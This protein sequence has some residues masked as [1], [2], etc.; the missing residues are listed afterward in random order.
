MRKHILIF[1]ICISIFVIINELFSQ[2]IANTDT[3]IET[4]KIN[5]LHICLPTNTKE[6]PIL[7]NREDENAYF[8]ENRGQIRND[9]VRY[10]LQGGGV[11]FLDDGVIFEIYDNQGVN[12]RESEEPLFSNNPICEDIEPRNSV[13]LKLNFKDANGIAPTGRGLLPHKSNYFY[14]NDS[15]KWC[16][17]VPNYQEIYYENLYNNIDLRY[18]SSDIGIKYDFIVHPGGEPNN[19]RMKYEGAEKLFINPQGDIVIRSSSC[20]FMDSQPYIYQTNNNHE[21][22]IN[23]R[24]NIFDSSTYGFEIPNE[25]DSNKPI[26]IDP[27]IYSTYAG[28]NQVDMGE[29]IVIDSNNNAYIT[30]FTESSN[31]PTTP[32]ANDT[33]HNTF[34]DV[35]VLKLDP[36]GSTLMFSTF[37]GGGWSEQGLDIA[38]DASYNV[39]VTGWSGSSN[40]PCTTGAFD[41]TY[42]GS[43]YD[44]IFLKLDPTGSTLLYSTYRGGSSSDQA[45]GN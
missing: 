27:L 7:L 10:Y 25:Y 18:Y 23:G 28:G 5:D 33:S 4:D 12:S 42:G 26:T 14:G 16:T 45:N 3:I 38:I 6:K 22:E 41:N 19:I 21:I 43:G 31:F 20:D 8:T 13:V 24:F 17:K 29:G 34:Y 2:S 36:T 39:Y 37:I 32:G 1:V 35:F 40:F 15:S 30:G 9:S 11:W 44:A